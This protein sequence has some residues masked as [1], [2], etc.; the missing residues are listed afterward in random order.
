M[1][2]KILHGYDLIFC[3]LFLF[4][5]PRSVFIR[6]RSVRNVFIRLRVGCLRQTL[7]RLDAI[8]DIL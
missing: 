2:Q 4:I 3:S 5:R 8:L 7:V 1:F 6:P